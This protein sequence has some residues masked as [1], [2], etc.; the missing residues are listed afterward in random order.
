MYR[1][2]LH[3]TTNATYFK[4]LI[5]RTYF[6][7]TGNTT[8]LWESPIWEWEAPTFWKQL[9]IGTPKRQAY[10]FWG[11]LQNNLGS[12]I[13]LQGPPNFPKSI[14]ISHTYSAT[15]KKKIYIH[16]V[17]IK[18]QEHYESNLSNLK[19]LFNS[20]ATRTSICHTLLECH[21]TRFL[22][23]ISQVFFK[24]RGGYLSIF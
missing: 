15:Q 1:F 24:K 7:R 8:P 18:R 9:R 20:F 3:G 11:P 4:G 10:L 13:E 21:L 23:I 6:K 22:H 16:K 2:Q 19:S 17:F 5:P 12:I 14:P